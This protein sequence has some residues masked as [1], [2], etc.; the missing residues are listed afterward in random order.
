MANL[1]P[2]SNLHIPEHL[3]LP[4]RELKQRFLYCYNK[5]FVGSASA[6][7]TKLWAAATFPSVTNDPKFGKVKAK[8]AAEQLGKL[9]PSGYLR[10]KKVLGGDPHFVASV[11][12]FTFPKRSHTIALQFLKSWFLGEQHSK[13]PPQPTAEH[14]QQSREFYEKLAPD[15]ETG[16]IATTNISASQVIEAMKLD[17]IGAAAL[18]AC[19]INV[20]FQ[21]KGNLVVIFA[22]FKIT[23]E[24]AQQL[25]TTDW[26]QLRD[27]DLYPPLLQWI[28]AGFGDRGLVPIASF[29]ISKIAFTLPANHVE[30]ARVNE[31]GLSIGPTGKPYYLPKVVEKQQTIAY[32]DKY[33]QAGSRDDGSYAL[34]DINEGATALDSG[35]EIKTKLPA[36]MVVSID[37]L[38]NKFAYTNTSGLLRVQDLTR[39]HKAD[40]S[41]ICQLMDD[42]SINEGMVD[43][44]VR[45]GD[46]A[47][48]KP[49]V[50]VPL[51]KDLEGLE[52][53]NN[54][55][56]LFDLARTPQ[57]WFKAAARAYKV[58]EEQDVV[59]VSDISVNG[60]GPFQTLAR[61]FTR[62][63]DA[64]LEN[65]DAVYLKYSV[66]TISEL[67]PWVLMISRYGKDLQGL[68]AADKTNRIAAMNQKVDPKWKPPSI[69]LLGDKIGFLPHQKKV[70]NLLKDSPDFAILPVQA[71]GGKSLLAITDILY[72]I[73]A[74]RNEPYLILCPSHLVPNYTQEIVDF[75]D[76]RLNIISINTVTIKQSGYKRLQAML[77]AMPRNSVVVAAYD[78]LRYQP[79]SLCYGTVPITYFPVIDFLRQFNFRYVFLDESHK[80][81]N[82]TAR[83]RAVMALISD[84]P[85]K[86]L[87]SGTMVHDSPSDLAIQIGMMD[88]TLFGSKDDFNA[89]Y[90]AEVRGGRVIAWNPGAQQQIMEKIKSRVVVAGAMRKEWA[91]LLPPKR[92]WIGG[93]ELTD[94]QQRVY[95]DI[96]DETLERIEEDAKTNKELQKFLRGNKASEKDEVGEG[97]TPEGEEEEEQEIDEDEGDDMAALLRPYLARLE[98]FLIAPGKD[99]LGSKILKGDDLISPKTTAILK[100][101]RAHIFGGTIIQNGKEVPYGPFPGK[102]LVFSNQ[103]ISAEEVWELAGPDLKKC[104]IL[105]KAANKVEDGSKFEKDPRVKW[106]VG[107]EVSM[108]EGLNLQ[109]A[110]RVIRCETVWN[111]GTL[112]QGNSRINRP[113]LKV[114][115]TRSEVFFDTIVADGTIDIT[116][117]ARLISKI[118]AAAKFEN[119]ENLDYETIPDVR[120]IKMNL[121][122]IRTLNTWHYISEEQPGLVTYAEALKKYE[123]VRDDDYK[124]YKEDYIA[125]HGADPGL[126]RVEQAPVPSDAK[127]MKHIPYVPGMNLYG[128]KELGLIRLDE[129]MNISSFTE[130]DEDEESTT[131]E[132]EDSDV[133]EGLTEQEQKAA[134][135]KGMPVHTEFGDG[136]IGKIDPFNKYVSVL[137][138]TG[139]NVRI[140]KNQVFLVTRTETS[141]KDM[142]NQLLKISGDLPVTESLT[143][144]ARQMRPSKAAQKMMQERELKLKSKETK[145]R[146]DKMKKDLSIELSLFVANGFLGVDYIINERNQTATQTLQAAGFRPQQPFYYAKVTNFTALK[147]QLNLWQN[148]GLRPDPTILK[149]GVR[150][151]FAELY[152]L[153]KSG[154]IKSHRETFK[155][156][157]AAKVVNF[158]RLE[159]KANNSKQ[160]YKPYPII[161][162]GL[163][164]IALPAQ[165]QAGTREAMKYKR[166]SFRW[167]LSDPTLSFFGSVQQVLSVV[168]HLE[169][170]GVQISNIKEFSAELQKLKKMPIRDPEDSDLE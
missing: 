34:V 143:V 5:G 106:M 68:R 12:L 67:L 56:G 103:V 64:V 167:Y 120:I 162:D 72:E 19:L 117:S 90:G 105:Y 93:V 40:V 110:S 65:I 38:N 62:V 6:F 109:F 33:T 44:F 94:A 121:A 79:K 147:N 83:S 31:Y 76:G 75:T 82:D 22:N 122:S 123:Q 137:L 74:N 91:A 3:Q 145:K 55:Q 87:A 168:K 135:V 37:W 70:R 84:I 78:T 61:Y 141:T 88:P 30:S 157:Q 92:E 95:D 52:L 136:V 128:L 60:W 107:V 81:K 48:I 151:A 53:S 100:R 158:Y 77:E 133:S 32:E 4:K 166:P 153:M 169:T 150:E 98:Q 42:R 57:D 50:M 118:V 144:P 131:D 58:L 127:L 36:N 11:P 149:Q 89:R 148:K 85:K 9:V 49:S 124:A 51:A 43:G 156:T 35:T 146:E 97:D 142:R 27:I 134:S 29:P 28:Q 7:M 47:G 45:M 66:T 170:S 59:K 163:A 99:A 160:L 17:A 140:R 161:Q 80:V 21:S 116:K 126:E 114:A 132:D 138:D 41:H 46:A 115:E 8:Q 129:F 23:K 25:T 96:L 16:Q 69:P 13:N 113:N 102:V 39:F 71:G 119:A 2:V 112:E 154:K 54:L 18:K 111:P 165:G 14:V 63:A 20:T 125:E 159:H 10:V 101:V 1:R 152:N 24:E 108:N 155:M 104:G 15:A 164:Y 86:R 73:K 130:E 26:Q 139:Y